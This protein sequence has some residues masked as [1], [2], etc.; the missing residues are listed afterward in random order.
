MVRQRTIRAAGNRQDQ[1]AG[2]PRQC[3][4]TA[5]NAI[6]ARWRRMWKC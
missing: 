2:S 4:T 1:P 3:Q 5:W 6:W